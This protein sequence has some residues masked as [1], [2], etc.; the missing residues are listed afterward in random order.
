[1]HASGRN[2]GVLHAGLYYSP[3]SLKARYCTEGNR[4]MKDFCRSNSL[5]LHETGK[6]IVANNADEDK[7]LEELKARAD[8][9]GARA[10]FVGV[11]ELRAIEPHAATYRRAL[12]SPDTAAIRP[13]EILHCLK[14]ELLG[15]GKAKL[16]NSITVEGPLGRRK[17]ATTGG[18]FS[19]ETMINAAGAHA[20][21]IAHRFGAAHDYKILPFKGTYMKIPPPRSSLVLGSIYPVPDLRNPFL[22]VHFSRGADGAVYVGPTA[23]PAAGRENYRMWEGWSRETAQIIMREGALL[24]SNP[25]FRDAALT[26]PRK[27]VKR[28]LFREARQLIPSLK[29]N[30]LARTPKVGIRPQL[31]HWPTKQLVMDFVT[32]QDPDALHVLNA[33]SPAFTCSMSFAKKIVIALTEGKEFTDAVPVSTA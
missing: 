2:S 4:L 24:F 5:T 17:V 29:L 15:S 27:Y 14:E 33:V 9:C 32:H 1:A 19:Y 16:I 10:R 23:I 3:D 11:E 30:D 18:V 6:V 25:A 31:V 21:S 28:V 13:L 8:A 22:G 26:E 20:D 7:R 12:H